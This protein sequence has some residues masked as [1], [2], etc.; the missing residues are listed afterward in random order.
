M[1]SIPEKDWK[2]FR[3]LH[4]TLM[5]RFCE[6]VL[7]E[8]V[9]VASNPNQDPSERFFAVSKLMRQSSKDMNDLGD[10]RRSTAFF[11]I[12]RMHNREKLFLADEFEKFS[13]ESREQIL[14]LGRMFE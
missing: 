2:V 12:A 14:G 10:H 4:G 1:N 3:D 9:R 7:Q 8:V 5:E 11:I 6:R 13:Q